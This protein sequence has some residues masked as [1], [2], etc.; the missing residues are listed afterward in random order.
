MLL[1]MIC[2]KKKHEPK[3]SL[4]IMVLIMTF[5]VTFV[6]TAKNIGFPSD[7]IIQWFKAW[8]FAFIVAFPTVILIMPSIKKIITKMVC[9]EN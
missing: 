9:N 3:V 4:F 5:I 6:S 7:F 1:K 8:G 2:I